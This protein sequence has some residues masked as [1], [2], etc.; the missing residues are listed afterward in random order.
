M[1][2]VEE[3]YTERN[4]KLLETTLQT[5]TC[6]KQLDNIEAMLFATLYQR[7]FTTLNR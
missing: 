7:Y 2:N 3:Q 5:F 4:M 1:K 6:S